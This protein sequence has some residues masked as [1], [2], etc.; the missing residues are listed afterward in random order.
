MNKKGVSSRIA[1]VAALIVIIIVACVAV[2]YWLSMQAPPP[3]SKGEPVKVAVLTNLSGGV[4]G[5]G[6]RAKILWDALI[7]EINAEKGIYVEKTGLYHTV[8]LIY[9]DCESSPSRSAE[10]ATKVASEGQVNLIFVQAGPPTITL[11]AVLSIEK[12]GNTPAIAEG[13][14]DTHI[15]L[16]LPAAPGGKYTWTW[17][18]HHS[19]VNLAEKNGLPFLASLKDRTNKVVGLL[20]EDDPDG[21]F[22][23]SSGYPQKL[24]D[25]GLTV[26]DPG[27]IPPGTADLTSIVV[28][29]KE[30]NVEMVYA[31]IM[32]D[33]GITFLRQSAGLG[34][35]PKVVVYTR[36]VS[37]AGSPD[38]FGD[39]AVGLV[40]DLFWWDTYPYPGNDWIR[41]NWPR[42]SG[43]LFYSSFEGY[44][45]AWVQVL[46]EAVKIAG[47]LD[48][49]AINEAFPK[50]ELTTPVG[51]VKFD[52]Q[53]HT[54]AGV[55]TLGQISKT[56]DGKWQI[57][58]VYAP[59][60]TGITTEPL[61]FPKPW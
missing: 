61:M 31:D 46:I 28:K 26:V 59:E 43:G 55:T 27:L 47:S 13:C 38:P 18:L 12:I 17:V 32:P 30:A 60:G 11:P 54:A 9:Y 35:K 45:Y 52:P 56:T 14:T 41:E 53:T 2:W 6:I 8:Q 16:G 44:A 29:F 49:K 33:T 37:A 3:P 23:Q 10:I 34:Y 20:F 21:H 58:V 4:A 15:Q 42:I 7:Y 24:R 1:I 51:K 36:A 40:K 25:A 22:L 48:K 39:L 57:K 5:M 19:L 50:V